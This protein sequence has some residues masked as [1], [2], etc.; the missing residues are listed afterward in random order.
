VPCAPRVCALRRRTILA[1]VTAHALGI[2]LIHGQ[3]SSPPISDHRLASVLLIP[4][5]MK[6]QKHGTDPPLGH[7]M[8]PISQCW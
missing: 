6:S 3:P 5:F 2:R 1:P 7:P 4:P 8:V